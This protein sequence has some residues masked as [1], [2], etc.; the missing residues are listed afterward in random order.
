MDIFTIDF[1]SFWSPTYSLTKMSPLEYVLGDEFETIS[2]SIKLN[3]YPTDVFFG[4]DNVAKAFKTIEGTLASSLLIAHN[5]S[6]FDAYVAHY[7][8]G[9]KP[10]MWGCTLAMAR[11]LHAKTVGLS[12][13]KLVQHYGLGT[14]NNAVLM[15]TR[16]KHLPDFT[17]DEL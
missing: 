16:G 7:V 2:C 3:D 13:A 5:M 11:P 8:F 1:E 6:A 17:P 10:K 15:Q 4:H 14:K 12:L 9:L